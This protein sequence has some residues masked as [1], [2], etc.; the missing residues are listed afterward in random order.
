[1]ASSVIAGF[2]NNSSYLASIDMYGNLLEQ[3]RV[4]TG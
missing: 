1:M 2:E 3:N 4:L